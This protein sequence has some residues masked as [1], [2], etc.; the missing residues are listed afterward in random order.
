MPY[1]QPGG[2]FADI[3]E[4]TKYLV[5]SAWNVVPDAIA[6]LCS[7]EAERRM[8]SA[9]RKQVSHD[10]LYD[11]LRPLLRFTKS[12]EGRLTGMSVLI[13]LFPS[14]SLA[15]LVDPLKI[16]L[17]YRGGGLIPPDDLVH[18]AAEI[19][20][21]HVNRLLADAP[22]SGPEDQR[23]YWVAPALMDGHHFDSL[24]KW[25]ID[26]LGGWLS[27]PVDG[28][29]ERGDRFREH[30]ELFHLVMDHKIDPP[31]GRPPA[32]L[33]E[34][35]SLMAVAAPGVCSLRS[36]HRLSPSLAWDSSAMLHGAVRISEGF[37]TLF[38]LPETIALLRGDQPDTFYWR[39]AL[40]HCLEGNIQSLLDEHGHCL[41]ESLGVIDESE[42][43][44]AIAIGDSIGS[45]L[46]IRTSQLHL[47]EVRVR[48]TMR[49]VELEGY[50]TRCRFAL[51]FAEL[52][53]E[54][55]AT[56]ARADTVREAFN[57]PFRPF[58][59][60]STSIGQEGLDFHTWCHAVVHWNLPSNPVDL[61]Q[62]EGRIHRYKGHAIR[63]NVALAYGLSALREKW[64][65]QSDPWSFMFDQARIDRS[66]G[67][68]DLVPYWLYEVEGGA[69]IERR[70][71]VL[72]YS[73]EEPH[74]H[75][76]KGML[77]VYRMV[78][79]QPRQED[80]LEYL[81]DQLGKNQGRFDLDM[82]RISLEPP[83]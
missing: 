15:N 53:D 67:V 24:K 74:F 51:R 11:E 2:S 41:V 66:S 14:P 5:F 7:Y 18:S 56:V 26:D 57:S 42:A 16:G 35:L 78:F 12:V 80:L 19:L 52:K 40:Q 62:R 22:D 47:D 6:A 3:N 29:S 54:V 82:W 45:A 27:I 63:K 21:P 79:G 9:F 64:D 39:L 36:L 65:Q 8:L 32:D 71:P 43:E 23:W 37:R 72:A 61:E 1:S 81:A 77:A 58:V 69:R 30:L 75:R 59:L 46:S 70:V 50:N 20:E 17:A 49:K 38:N 25:L 83:S 10:K 76:L 4:V 55:G 44:R 33:I 68:N 60:A 48:P 31:L 28:P 34:V 13:L 73:K